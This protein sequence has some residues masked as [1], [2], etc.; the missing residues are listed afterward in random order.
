MKNKLLNLLILISA[1]LVLIITSPV[2]CAEVGGGFGYYYVTSSPSGASVSLDGSFQGLSPIN[3]PIHVDATPGHTIKVEKDGY[4]TWEQY[5]SGNPGEGDTV[6]IYAQLVSSF[7]PV[8]LPP[9]IGGGKG[10]Y[11]ISS[12]PSGADIS[13]DGVPKGTAPVVVEVST[14]GTPGH[15]IAA[16]KSGYLPW[17]Q[18]ETGNPMQGETVY[19]VADMQPVSPITPPPGSGKGYYSV[20]SL[21]A[22]SS[23]IMDGQNEGLSPVVIEVS[24]DGAPGHTFT[25]TK[26]GYQTWKWTD[27]GN[28]KRDETVPVYAELVP[29][30]TV[31]TQTTGSIFVQ[32]V[33][34]GAVATLDG[35]YGQITPTSFV[36]VNPYY[37][38]V[39]VMLPG[40]Q[41]WTNTVYVNQGETKTITANL[42]PVGPKNGWISINSIPSGA[43][44]YIDNSYRGYTPSTIGGLSPGDHNVELRLAGYQTWKGTSTVTAGGTNT[45]TVT[46]TKNQPQTKT[47]DIS[48]ISNPGGASVSLNGNYQG[49][50]KLVDGLDIV[51]LNPGSY[52]MLLKKTGYNDYTTTVNVVADQVATINAAL[53]KSSTPSSTGVIDINSQPTGA[54][55]YLDN[56]YKGITPLTLSNI[57][58]GD[59]NVILKM[60]GYTDW[61]TTVTI[62]GGDT[63][64]LSATMQPT[65]VTTTQTAT[66]V[67]TKKSP[68]Q[69]IFVIGALLFGSLY[70]I[71]RGRLR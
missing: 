67:P 48:V 36:G 14:D 44:I 58:A 62:K 9:T 39:Q 60:N 46:L 50:T 53:V 8:T 45:V 38:T 17:Q 22:G 65:A 49:D 70:F 21:P 61:T 37:H 34:S 20:T 51:G 68:V 26:A 10:Y 2:N 40:Y 23:V 13:F 4:E 57:P 11:S 27:P 15:V 24:T 1:C 3:L 55:I 30:T 6:N 54:D 43:D 35:G 5:Q 12:S 41:V 66:E 32:S 31:P 52:T 33:P 28:P 29:V 25:V 42:V 71:S 7:K 18:S 69:P 16:S 47:G 64:Q 63:A 56:A 59:H 19:V